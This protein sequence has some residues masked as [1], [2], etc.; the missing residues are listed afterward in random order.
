MKS[1]ANL[2][3]LGVILMLFA[4]ASKCNLVDPDVTKV[5]T[6]YDDNPFVTKNDKLRT[7]VAM[8]VPYDAV[9]KEEDV[10]CESLI[11]G[12]FAVAHFNVSIKEHGDAWEYMYSTWLS[13]NNQ[14]VRDA[15]PF[16]LCVEVPASNFRDKTKMDVYTPIL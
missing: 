16:E 14:Q 3:K 15:V 1:V 8:T 4:Y 11:K 2:M 12:K 7:S 10:I 5:L 6:V 9:I 13:E